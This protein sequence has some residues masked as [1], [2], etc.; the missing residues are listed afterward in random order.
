MTITPPSHASSSSVKVLEPKL[1]VFTKLIT[2]KAG[3]QVPKIDI[4]ISRLCLC[5]AFIHSKFKLPFLYNIFLQFSSLCYESHLHLH[6]YY[7][8]E[9]HITEMHNE[10]NTST[11]VYDFEPQC[12]IWVLLKLKNFRE[13]IPCD[14]I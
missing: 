13:L 6:S 10:K 9:T 1:N 8:N 11:V 14:K 3:I 2:S 12:F 7:G 5:C 4:R